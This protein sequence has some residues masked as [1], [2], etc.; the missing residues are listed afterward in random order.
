MEILVKKQ[1][2]D[3]ERKISKLCQIQVDLI[4]IQ[5]DFGFINSLP[6]LFRI[7]NLRKDSFG[8]VF[9]R[10]IQRQRALA[11]FLFEGSCQAA[12]D[13]YDK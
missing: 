9:E 13:S 6:Q 11:D 1:G 10:F 12:Q 8:F 7:Y 2:F 3:I 5:R 4:G